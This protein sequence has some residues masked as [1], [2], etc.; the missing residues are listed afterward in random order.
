MPAAPDGGATFVAGLL[1]EPAFLVPVEPGRLEPV[2]VCLTAGFAVAGGWAGAG[3][4]AGSGRDV[5]AAAG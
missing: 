5:P 2:V 3:G 1:D 4:T